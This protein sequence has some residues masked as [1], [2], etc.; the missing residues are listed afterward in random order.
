MK[1]LSISYLI[2][3]VSLDFISHLIVRFSLQCTLHECGDDE[4]NIKESK[5]FKSNWGSL[6][7]SFPCFFDPSPSPTFE[8][9]SEFGGNYSSSRGKAILEKT[10]STHVIHAMLWPI[11]CFCIGFLMWFG[12]CVGC[13]TI[14]LRQFPD[15]PLVDR[16]SVWCLE[17]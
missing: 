12:L 16:T 15:L 4:W 3:E 5:N 14:E 1:Y 9:S 6:H 17:Q 7:K 10:S 2:Y 8:A 13:C 11:V